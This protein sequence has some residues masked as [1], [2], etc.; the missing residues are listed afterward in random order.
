MTVSG[1]RRSE[2]ITVTSD[3][4]VFEN[5]DSGLF[6]RAENKEIK[7]VLQGPVEDVNNVL[8]HALDSIRIRVDM[9]GVDGASALE[10]V[11]GYIFIPDY[12]AVGIVNGKVQIDVAVTAN[13]ADTQTEQ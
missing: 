13:P 1:I 2:A 8:E 5:I 10:T 9:S 6:A 12:P 3:Q 7:I 11:D 4:I